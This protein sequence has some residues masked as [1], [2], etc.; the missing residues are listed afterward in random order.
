MTNRAILSCAITLAIV[1]CASQPDDSP[2]S[3][4]RAI[5]TVGDG[6]GKAVTAPLDDLNLRRDEIPDQLKAIKTPY[7]LDPE[8]SCEQIA[9]EVEMLNSLLGRDWDIPPPEKDSIEDRAA[10]GA[11]TA[12][13]DTLASGTSGLIPYRGVVRS[14]TGADRHQKK[15][16]KAYERG[17]HRR[18][19]LKGIG[20]TKGCEGNAAPAPPPPVDPKV[21]F[22]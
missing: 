16:L 21:V 12:F 14:L 17:S 5:T 22:K 2:S 15:V 11:S 10:D 1:G 19:F 8:I 18:T 20:M 9:A 7:S 4:E 6:A 13:L 3:T